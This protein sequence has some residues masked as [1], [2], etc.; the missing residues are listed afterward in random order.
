M[1]LT[2]IKNIGV[3]SAVSIVADAASDIVQQTLD[4]RY[5]SGSTQ[6]VLGSYCTK[7]ILNTVSGSRQDGATG[8]ISAAATTSFVAIIDEGRSAASAV[9]SGVDSTGTAIM[10]VEKV[11]KDNTEKLVQETKS[12]NPD[13]KRIAQLTTWIKQDNASL[14]ELDTREKKLIS[15]MF[16]VFGL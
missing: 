2:D 6:G 8:A 15:P 7:L 5:G 16:Y 10:N 11:L 1:S 12:S 4:K 3:N 9:N 13:K 14:Q